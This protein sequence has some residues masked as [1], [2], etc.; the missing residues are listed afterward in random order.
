MTLVVVAL[1]TGCGRVAFD[2]AGDAQSDTSGDAFV[3][4]APVGHDED[5]DLVDDACDVCPHI[6]DAAQA[7]GDGD[8]V[9]DACDPRPTTPG[10]NIALFDAFTA[11]TGW[12]PMNSLVDATGA[13][14]DGF[15]TYAA[16]R[17]PLVDGRY[18]FT[19][20]GAVGAGASPAY[21]LQILLSGSGGNFYYC[22]LYTEPGI[23]N[24]LSWTYSIDGGATY[25]SDSTTPRPNA[26]SGTQGSLSMSIEGDGGLCTTDWDGTSS[27][28]AGSRHGIVLDTLVLAANNCNATLDY[29][30]AIRSN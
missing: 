24:S 7:D 16:L 27:M 20:G 23:F 9:G 11:D 8:G 19:V 10:D 15:N 22:E 12:S 25:P 4:M 14:L 17:R 5:G 29:V 3:C 6:A 13:H 2:G 1:V 28:A 18:H 21:H 26:L 30:I